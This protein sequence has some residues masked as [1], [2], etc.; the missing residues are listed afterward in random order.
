MFIESYTETLV[1]LGL[2]FTLSAITGKLAW[3]A[4]HMKDKILGLYFISMLVVV[5]FLSIGGIL[6]I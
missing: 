5:W 3:I 2:F 6:V 4:Y 1:K